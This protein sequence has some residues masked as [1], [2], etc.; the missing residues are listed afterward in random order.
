MLVVATW[1]WLK[2]RSHLVSR[3]LVSRLVFRKWFWSA[4]PS[5]FTIIVFDVKQQ[6]TIY[7]Q[8]TFYIYVSLDTGSANAI[9]SLPRDAVRAS[10]V[11]AVIVCLSVR[12]SVCLSLAGTVSKWLNVGSRKQRRTIAQ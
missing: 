1:A 2:F 11:Y 8:V 9:L 10:A 12:P 4:L 5:T 6:I 7:R 3:T